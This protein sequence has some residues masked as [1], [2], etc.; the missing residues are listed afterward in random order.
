MDRKTLLNFFGFAFVV[1]LADQF[2]DAGFDVI[3]VSIS[4]ALVM[5]VGMTFVL[6]LLVAIK[7]K[8]GGVS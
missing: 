4:K 2:L 1:Y 8:F 6:W 5:S 7:N 3:L